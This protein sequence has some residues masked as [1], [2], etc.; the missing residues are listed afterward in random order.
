MNKK[1]VGHI[2]MLIRKTKAESRGT[3]SNSQITIPTALQDFQLTSTGSGV[4]SFLPFR[5]K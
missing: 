4:H 3:I 5:W 2:D 1:N